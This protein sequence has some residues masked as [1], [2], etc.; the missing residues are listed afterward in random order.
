MST[1]IRLNKRLSLRAELVLPA[2]FLFIFFAISLTSIALITYTNETTQLTQNQIK[3]TSQQVLSNY[4]T[5]FDGVISISQNVQT[6]V[7]N[8]DIYKN[9]DDISSYFDEVMSF[10]KEIRSMA[11]YDNQKNLIV[12]DSKYLPNASEKNDEWSNEAKRYP[13]INIFSR[14]E[15]TGEVYEFSL[16]KYV[17]FDKGTQNGIL[18][19]DFNF[20]KIIT[21]ITRT[22]LGEGGHITIYDREY[23]IVYTSD[24][25]TNENET[26]V[27]KELVM[28]VKQVTLDKKYVLFASTITNTTWRVA[29]FT[30]NE[31]LTETLM[32]FFGDVFSSTLIVIL[33]FS[34][35]MTILGSSIVRPLTKL[36]KE[37]V[38]VENFDYQINQNFDVGGNKE[39]QELSN[40]FN[41]MME[42]IK[43]L[44][45]RV[46]EEQEEQR[47]SELKALQNQINPHFL[48][49][50]FDSI[51]YLIEKNE[52]EKAEKMIVALSKFLRISVSKGKNVIPLE[53]EIEH[54]K[55][56]LQIQKI[57]FGDSFVYEVN[58]VPELY[59]YY[60]IKLILQPI[61]ENAIAHGISE[62]TSRVGLIK[63]NGYI[64]DDFIYLEVIDN[65]YGI[66][67]S[68]IDEIYESFKN[69][70]AHFG[71]GI[72][73]VYER[74][75]I[76]YGNS[77][78]LLI[79]SELDVGTKVTIIIPREGAINNEETN[80][81]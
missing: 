78:N 24:H 11:I 67:Q 37:M 5:Y 18:K 55:Y 61:V 25:R 58:V 34:T 73:N 29:I 33:I 48:Y 35:F 52:N 4:N 76:Y 17:N 43:E 32:K 47:K 68:K 14:V 59:K 66:L 74:I 80:H 13:L 56:Y 36:Q 2:I 46:L 64:K 19:I 31:A 54:V 6:K 40:S 44:M 60:V 50:T 22:D 49:N 3:A 42:R 7:D 26:A 30:N 9:K 21:L 41:Q 65:G 39:V 45:K 28:G 69:K 10:K 71:V 57:K 77:A 79:E 20:N 53:K 62:M 27:V 16:S 70:N 12:S 1:K 72:K 15:Y 75:K 63:I 81:F 38:K 8:I 51:I 23:N